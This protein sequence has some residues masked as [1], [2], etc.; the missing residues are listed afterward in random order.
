MWE[1][2]NSTGD[3]VY[4]HYS[5]KQKAGEK[6]TLKWVLMDSDYFIGTWQFK[7]HFAISVHDTEEE[8]EKAIK[9]NMAI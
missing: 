1:T 5:D 8:A 6:A 2:V 3:I 9:T 4:Y 7:E